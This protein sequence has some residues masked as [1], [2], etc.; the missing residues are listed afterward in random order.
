MECKQSCEATC[1]STFSSSL[2][3]RA[4]RRP[5]RTD[6]VR[7]G[8]VPR[9]IR[10]PS[11]AR[12]PCLLWRGCRR[13]AR[14]ERRP[15]PSASSP[16]ERLAGVDS[17]SGPRSGRSGI[18]AQLTTASRESSDWRGSYAQRE[19]I[20]VAQATSSSIANNSTCQVGKSRISLTLAEPL[21]TFPGGFV[22]P[23]HVEPQTRR[24]A[25]AAPP[26][27]RGDGFLS[28]SELPFPVLI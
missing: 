23:C 11:R 26:S 24:W 22:F 14:L 4:A 9:R 16:I 8:T 10:R 12:P 3:S 6:C 28:L 1:T 15:Q 13:A 17:R 25:S 5:S 2:W 7:H 20:P 19:T 21:T 18:S 27:G